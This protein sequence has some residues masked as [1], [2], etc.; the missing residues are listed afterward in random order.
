MVCPV[1]TRVV[2]VPSAS[3]SVR[4]TGYVP[5]LKSMNIT[6]LVLTTLPS[7]KFQAYSVIGAPWATELLALNMPMKPHLLWIT[8]A[9]AVKEAMGGWSGVMAMPLGPVPTVIGDP[10]VLLAVLIG[11]TVSDPR[12]TT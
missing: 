2:D 8:R 12:L 9:R 3:V 1:N 7:P 10:V 4:T 11:V 6:G 5:A